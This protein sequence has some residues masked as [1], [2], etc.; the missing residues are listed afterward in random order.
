LYG[1]SRSF[2]EGFVI[3]VFVLFVLN[4]AVFSAAP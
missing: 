4:L 3:G 1:C 2:P